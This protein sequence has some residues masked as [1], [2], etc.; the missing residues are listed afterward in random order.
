MEGLVANDQVAP[1][2]DDSAEQSSGNFLHN[3]SYKLYINNNY[4]H[5]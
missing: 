3:A 1:Q 2:S 4:Y 5:R